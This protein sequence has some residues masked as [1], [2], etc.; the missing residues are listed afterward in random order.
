MFLIGCSI[1]RA[2]N[3]DRNILLKMF[4][5]DIF[6]EI[7][8]KFME[9]DIRKSQFGKLVLIWQFNLFCG[10]SAKSMIGRH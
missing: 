1:L 7:S 8:K 10:L 5:K 4:L 2:F 3:Y 9:I 6:I